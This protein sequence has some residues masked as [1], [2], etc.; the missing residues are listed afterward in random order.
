VGN[1]QTADFRDKLIAVI[2]QQRHYLITKGAIFE[3]KA[4][5]IQ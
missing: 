3:Q 1:I 5:D 4:A 2:L